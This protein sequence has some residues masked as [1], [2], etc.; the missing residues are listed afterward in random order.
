M[1]NILLAGIL[2]TC[3]ISAN[4]EDTDSSS[5]DYTGPSSE[6]TQEGERSSGPILYVGLGM[7]SASYKREYNKGGEKRGSDSE[8]GNQVAGSFGGGWRQE[9]A[10]GLQASVIAGV[11]CGK[12][13]NI[14]INASGE[15]IGQTRQ[16]WFNPELGVR[17]GKRC[18]EKKV[19]ILINGRYLNDKIRNNENKEYAEHSQMVASGGLGFAWIV[20]AR[21]ELFVEADKSLNTSKTST[22][23]SKETKHLREDG[24]SVRM[25]LVCRL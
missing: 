5:E 10:N 17:I 7:N 19:Y 8:T 25:G 6:V 11:V 4:A 3:V 18:G 20:S 2:S 13:K 22:V 1:K 12:S 16:G 21:Y 23:D 15:K 14:D 9:L 24:Y